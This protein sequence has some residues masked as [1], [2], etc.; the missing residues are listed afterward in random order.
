MQA[1]CAQQQMP[2]APASSSVSEQMIPSIHAEQRTSSMSDDANVTALRHLRTTLR[3]LKLDSAPDPKSVLNLA[4]MGYMRPRNNIDLP[5]KY[6]T[7]DVPGGAKGFTASVTVFGHCFV[8]GPRCKK[9]DAEQDAAAEVITRLRAEADPC[10][11]RPSGPAN[12]DT[13]GVPHAILT[14]EQQ[15]QEAL[16]R[17]LL[18]A[19]EAAPDCRSPP[20]SMR[21]CSSIITRRVSSRSRSRSSGRTFSARQ[22][23]EDLALAISLSLQGS[24]D[25]GNDRY[26]NMPD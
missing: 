16:R 25:A 3:K 24:T 26:P 13:E 6:E 21:H 7:S 19:P 1:I 15:L 18:E 5:V 8:G 10:A 9:Q 2:G 4:V 12:H 23:E 20:M 22:E 17:S 14:E 11:S